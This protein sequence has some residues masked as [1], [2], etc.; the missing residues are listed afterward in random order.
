LTF[1]LSDALM[2]A[3]LKRASGSVSLQQAPH[4]EEKNK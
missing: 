3:A 1:H 4:V 2:Q